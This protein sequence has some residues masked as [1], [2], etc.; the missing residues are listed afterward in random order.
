MSQL[1]EAELEV[2]RVLW[3]HGTM[4]PPEIEDQLPGKK[5][6]ALR[7]ILQTL[8]EKGHVSR[9][10]IGRAYYYRAETERES[11]LAKWKTKLAGLFTGGSP[12]ALIAEFIRQEKLSEE[13]LRELAR[14]AQKSG[15][16]SAE[17]EPDKEA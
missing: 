10:K 11:E 13:D 17:T 14:L 6:A 2:M 12:R 9:R 16:P 4:K 5:N 7:A 8:C 1:T 15:K 3:K